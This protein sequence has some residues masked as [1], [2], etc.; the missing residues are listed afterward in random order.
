M[1]RDKELQI[2]NGLSDYFEDCLLYDIEEEATLSLFFGV[3]GNIHQQTIQRTSQ[4][5]QLGLKT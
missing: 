5:F 4:R 2:V 1:L 3:H